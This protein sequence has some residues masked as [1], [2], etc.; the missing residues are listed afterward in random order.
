M[1][2]D[3]LKKAAEW[4]ERALRMEEEGKTSMMEKCLNRAIEFENEGIKAG[5]SWD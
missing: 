2:G 5:E 1:Q 3:K 4:F